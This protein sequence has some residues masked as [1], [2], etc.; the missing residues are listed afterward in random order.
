MM[1]IFAQNESGSD[2][3]SSSK[4]S[5][6]AWQRQ[7]AD[8]NTGEGRGYHPSKKSFLHLWARAVEFSR[9]CSDSEV[10]P[11]G[12]EGLT[13]QALLSHT[14]IPEI[15]HAAHFLMPMWFFVG[16]WRPS[17]G[18]ITWPDIDLMLSASF[19]RYLKYPIE[20]Q[21]KKWT[22]KKQ[23]WQTGAWMKKVSDNFSLGFYE[24]FWS[25]IWGCCANEHNNFTKVPSD[26]SDSGFWFNISANIRGSR[27]QLSIC[28]AHQSN[29]YH[30]DASAREI[31]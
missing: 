25:G 20:K 9:E 17:L 2:A 8:A 12:G 5:K 11:K 23:T 28:S 19:F 24:M 26:V 21:W 10:K 7:G 1:W 30:S 18:A 3:Q 15:A 16:S 4:S 14:Y 22:C 29:L 6:D 13:W 27:F 31:P